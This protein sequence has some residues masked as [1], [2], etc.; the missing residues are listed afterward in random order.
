M[1]NVTIAKQKLEDLKIRTRN[2]LY[3]MSVNDN[4]FNKI[5]DTL[6]SKIC[7]ICE[8]HNLECP[9]FKYLD[10][11]RFNFTSKDFY[12]ALELLRSKYSIFLDLRAKYKKTYKNF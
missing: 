5:D 10:Y 6:Y 4:E 3:L 7:D 9:I 12:D 8:S 1:C 2:D 11:I